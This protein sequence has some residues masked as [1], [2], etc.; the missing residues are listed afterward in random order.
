MQVVKNLIE[1]DSTLT[2]TVIN[3]SELGF[4]RVLAPYFNELNLEKRM[5]RYKVENGWLSQDRIISEADDM[6]EI[7]KANLIDENMLRS[8]AFRYIINAFISNLTQENSLSEIV[9]EQKRLTPMLATELRQSGA[10]TLG[11]F[12]AD[13]LNV[14]GGEL[15]IHLNKNEHSIFLKRDI[16]IGELVIID[17]QRLF[18]RLGSMMATT[19]ELSSHLDI[20]V[21]SQY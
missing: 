13:K 14:K 20:I 16:S 21:L 9:V 2:P 7:M 10:K 15:S 4:H 17:D 6:Q 18:H 1:Q 19:D 12:V 5:A 11:F 8:F 3:F